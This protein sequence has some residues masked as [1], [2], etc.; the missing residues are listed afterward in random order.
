LAW[1]LTQPHP[2]KLIFRGAAVVKSNWNA[3]DEHGLA[4]KREL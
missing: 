3:A 2:G 1:K 4:R